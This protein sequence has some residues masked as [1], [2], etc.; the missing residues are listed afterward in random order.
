MSIFAKP[1]SDISES[2]LQDLLAEHAVEN[3]RLEF[4][5]DVPD[6]HGTL[7]KLSGFAN[8]FGG[9]VVIGAEAGSDGRLQ[10]LPGVAPQ[11][12]YKQTIVQ[13]CFDGASPPIDVEVSDPISLAGGTGRVCYV[14]GVGESDRG[15]HF[16][17]GRKGL[18]VRSNEF[19]SRFEAQL[20]T[21]SEFRHLLNRRQ[22]VR[23][24]R[25]ELVG[26]ARDRFETF[27]SQKYG[28]HG[29]RSHQGIGA[30]FDL[31]VG[32]TFP[33]YPL[34][35]SKKL[36]S[37]IHSK[38]LSWRQVGFPR[39]TGA[40]RTITQHESVISLLPGS[41][42]SILEANTWG[43]LYYATE[44]ERET[45]TGKNDIAGINPNYVI[46]H[47]LV[48]LTHAGIVLNELG[49]TGPLTIEMKLDSI[50]GVRWLRFDEPWVGTAPGSHLDDSVA[51][52]LETTAEEL[53]T[54]RDGIVVNLMRYVFFSTDQ[55]DLTDANALKRYVKGGHEFNMWGTPQDLDM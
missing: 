19:S 50:R 43:L 34:C 24:R 11:A 18:Y 37:I 16:L 14:I 28:E 45:Q 26:R 2:D 39:T 38:R 40:G 22:L 25:A 4:K 36:L 49:Y 1:V 23:E 6:K 31:S 51:L 41:N 46:G 35:D 27:T 9:L 53:L 29:F 17:N 5:R 32:P 3:L 52:S 48:F 10:S 42:F 20:A 44:I 47:L 21:E 30:R 33:A 12:S 8:T 55:A 54:R 13:W 15:P 7:T